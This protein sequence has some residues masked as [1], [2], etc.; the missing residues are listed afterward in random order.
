MLF[1]EYFKIISLVLLMIISSLSFS[2]TVIKS[3]CGDY[4]YRVDRPDNQ[5]SDSNKFQ[6]YSIKNNLKPNKFYTSN[7][8]GFIITACIQNNKGKY[9]FLFQE[10]SGGNTPPEVINGIFDPELNQILMNP[11]DWPKGND[12]E[13]KELLGYE[14][15]SMTFDNRTFCC[16]KEQL[17]TEFD[18]NEA[19]NELNWV[20]KR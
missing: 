20:T 3:K 16:S 11:N 19:I 1:V 10:L 2:L 14:L 9:L 15:P 8:V 5:D 18:Y 6:L 12:D 17:P 4:V 13:V 7:H